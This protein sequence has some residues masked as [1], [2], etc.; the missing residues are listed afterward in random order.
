MAYVNPYRR[1][2]HR[3]VAAICNLW[4]DTHT[5]TVCP[6]GRHSAAV[7]P[8]KVTGTPLPYGTVWHFLGGPVG[9]EG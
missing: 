3:E 2:L 9:L 5:L 7:L 8:R 4:L 1:N 6:K